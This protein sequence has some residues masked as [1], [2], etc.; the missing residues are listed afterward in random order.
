MKLLFISLRLFGLTLLLF[1]VLYPAAILGLAK[2][3]PNQGEGVVNTLIGQDFHSDTFFWGRPSAVGYN[4]AA[5]GGSNQGPTNPAHLQLVHDRIDT[6][7]KYHT[8]LKAADIPSEWVT[9]SG[10]GLDPHLSVKATELQ[11]E[12]VAKARNLST[13]VVKKLVAQ[14]T[15]TKTLGPTGY[16]NILALNKA[17]AAIK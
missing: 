3:F 4:A 1:G 6:L 12:R 9:A 7:L 16:V 13:D 10:G 17:L 2:A 8:Y 11:I 5:T 15:E 14:Y